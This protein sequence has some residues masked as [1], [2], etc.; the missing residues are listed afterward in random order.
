MRSPPCHLLERSLY[1]GKKPKGEGVGDRLPVS[2]SYE[3]KTAPKARANLSSILIG[4]NC[5]TRPFLKH[6]P[7]REWGCSETSQMDTPELR[8][9]ELLQCRGH[10]GF[11]G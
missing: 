9:D 4:L 5:T 7:V 6:S 11:P 10:V 1:Q 2:S 8:V 3:Q